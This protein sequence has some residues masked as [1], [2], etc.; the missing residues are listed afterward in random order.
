M[1]KIYNTLIARFGDEYTVL[2]D[3]SE[4]AL[5]EVVDAQVASAILRVR[6][7]SITVV[8]GFDGVYG[9]LVLGEAASAEVSRE[10]K[11]RGNCSTDEPWRLLV[12]MECMVFCVF[13]C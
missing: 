5:K 6:A 3:A 11:R 8:P 2:L 7:G 1:W 10:V 12:S 13:L 4:E 9:K